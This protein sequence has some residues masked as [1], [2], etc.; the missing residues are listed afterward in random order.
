MS[1]ILG[2]GNGTNNWWELVLPIW[3]IVGIAYVINF[4]AYRI[5]RWSQNRKNKQSG[6]LI[7]TDNDNEHIA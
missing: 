6:Q 1:I 4:T 5:K 3:I 7:N 2:A